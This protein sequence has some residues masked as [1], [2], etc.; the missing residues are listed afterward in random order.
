M[1]KLKTYRPEDSITLAGDAL[2]E[3]FSQI[4]PEV[5]KAQA[6]YNQ[7]M[8]PAY[9]AYNDDILVAV[10]GVRI[11]RDNSGVPWFMLSK[12]MARKPK[13]VLESCKLMLDILVA[14]N[15]MK[16]LRTHMEIGNR[17]GQRWL[18]CLGFTR[19]RRTIMHGTH[20]YYKREA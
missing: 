12:T 20:Y 13:M 9:S 17:P 7:L 6:E 14:E 5:L 4:D 18:E 8:G 10:G 3:D 16:S 15:S 19:G 2:G 11:R 1:L